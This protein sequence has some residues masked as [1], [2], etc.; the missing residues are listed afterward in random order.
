MTSVAGDPVTNSLRLQQLAPWLGSVIRRSFAEEVYQSLN[1]SVRSIFL[2]RI[3]DGQVELLDKPGFQLRDSFNDSS[4]S[5][6]EGAVIYRE[7][8]IRAHMY[9]DFFARIL[10]GSASALDML[11]AVDV[12]DAPIETAEA[13]VFAFQK[14]VGSNTVLI[15]DVDF[16]HTNF[17]IPAEYRDDTPYAGKTPWAVFAGSTTAG[18]TITAADV[19]TLAIPRLRAG[20]FFKG[21]RE[22]DF[23]VPR[24]VQ[25][26]SHDVASMVASLGINAETC[27]WQQQFKYRFVLS[28]D[29]NGA[30]CSRVVIGLLSN[31]ALVKYD[32]PHQLYYFGALVPWRHFIPVS[33]D[34][35]VPPVV[36]AERRQPMIF[37]HV[38]EEGRN[39][40]RRYLGRAG[41]CSYGV[42]LLSLFHSCLSDASTR[43]SP[44]A[45]TAVQEN[46]LPLVELGAHVQ[47]TGDV[48]GWPGEWVGAPGSGQAI[49]AIAI[50]PTGIP[51]EAIG[52]RVLLSDGSLS[53]ISQFGGFCGTRGRDM[54]LLGFELQL[55]GDWKNTLSCSYTGHFTDGTRIGPL[56]AGELCRSPNGAKLE[57]YQVKIEEIR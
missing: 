26:Q 32:S 14:P 33:R 51:T 48:W 47:G 15:P 21:S 31:S 50:V 11:I 23:R 10:A 37:A 25:C 41:V 52:C 27:S 40:A 34:E 49:E 36:E 46:V 9:R 56:G 4:Q 17:Y 13:P 6:P 57:A 42:E 22:V 1:L 45:V 12:N 44:G 8:F 54:P 38:A 55:C 35:D 16:L 18:R 20:V 2:Y 24:I 29:G 28:M 5:E 53:N 30:T 39:F 3:R 19:E 7:E 43:R